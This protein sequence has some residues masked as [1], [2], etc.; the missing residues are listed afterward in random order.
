[1]GSSRAELTLEWHREALRQSSEQRFPFATERSH[2]KLRVA[3]QRAGLFPPIVRNTSVQVSPTPPLH[4][5][6]H[7]WGHSGAV[8]VALGVM[9]TMELL[10]IPCLEVGEEH[11]WEERGKNSSVSARAAGEEGEG[12]G[13]GQAG[14]L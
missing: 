11:L 12:G 4:P 6:P 3:K 10:E 7:P 13:G 9:V 5:L 14:A 2:P 8:T 1:M